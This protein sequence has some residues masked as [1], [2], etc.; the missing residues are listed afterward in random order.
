MDD[1][2]DG[3]QDLPLSAYYYNSLQPPL[4][5][6]NQS[7]AK[8]ITTNIHMT[9]QLDRNTGKCSGEV[10]VTVPGQTWS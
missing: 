6:V 8:V 10:T 4:A 3:T 9:K 5:Y 1:E 2:H 7:T